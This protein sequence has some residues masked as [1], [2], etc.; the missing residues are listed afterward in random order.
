[1]E[2]LHTNENP[3]PDEGVGKELL[4]GEGGLEVKPSFVLVFENVHD[5]HDLQENMLL[6]TC[7]GSGFVHGESSRA[8]DEGAL[9]VDNFV[10]GFVE[11]SVV[12][13]VLVMLRLW[14]MSQGFCLVM[15]RSYK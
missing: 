6:I 12:E 8:Q 4:V 7:K 15:S 11:P 1:M 10:S 13:F 9:I 2:D 5:M 3:K 14:E